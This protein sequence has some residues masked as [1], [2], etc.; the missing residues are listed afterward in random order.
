MGKKSHE[1]KLQALQKIE[2]EKNAEIRAYKS[3]QPSQMDVTLGKY[4]VKAHEEKLRA[5]AELS[6]KKN[7]EIFKLRKEISELRNEKHLIAEYQEFIS[8]YMIK[9]QEEKF[10]LMQQLQKK[11]KNVAKNEVTKNEVTKNEVTKNEVATNEISREKNGTNW[12]HE[13]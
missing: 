4:M 3:N 10:L 8:N 2:S 13:I 12:C 5:L 9:A 6:D 7:A 11:H 1:E